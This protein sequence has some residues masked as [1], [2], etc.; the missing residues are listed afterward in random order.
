MEAEGEKKIII[1]E[2]ICFRKCVKRFN[3]ADAVLCLTLMK[4]ERASVRI[5]LKDLW[6]PLENEEDVQDGDRSMLEPGH[7]PAH[8]IIKQAV[9][10]HSA[11][12]LSLPASADQNR[13]VC[14]VLPPIL[15]II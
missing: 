13:P 4:R 8:W 10:F 6:S 2:R 12:L 5:N 14:N 1:N 15:Q 3:A 11:S 7:K 9:C